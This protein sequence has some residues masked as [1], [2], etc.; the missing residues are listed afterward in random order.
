M[1]QGAGLI[2]WVHVFPSGP[3]SAEINPLCRSVKIQLKPARA[4]GSSV[5][6]GSLPAE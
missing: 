4:G 3:C 6:L 2:L 5:A 1:N